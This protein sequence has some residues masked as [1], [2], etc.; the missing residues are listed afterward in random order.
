[1]I[2]LGK[3][4]TTLVELAAGYANILVFRRLCR[5]NHLHRLQMDAVH[6]T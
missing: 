5:E 4:L 6:F 2:L 1:M 3:H